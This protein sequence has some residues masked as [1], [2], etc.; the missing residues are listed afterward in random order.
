MIF[1]KFN[2]ILF[3]KKKKK[4]KN[5]ITLPSAFNIQPT[6]LDFYGNM[7]PNLLGYKFNNTDS[8]MSTLHIWKF[9]ENNVE[10]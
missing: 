6:P 5:Y 10:M 4:K 3:K 9:T 1:T 7:H 2:W 8:S